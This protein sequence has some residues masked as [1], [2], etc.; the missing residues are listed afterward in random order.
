MIALGAGFFFSQ[1]LDKQK[2]IMGFLKFKMYPFNFKG[3]HY[4]CFDKYI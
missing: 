4:F 1:C 3:H 2:Y